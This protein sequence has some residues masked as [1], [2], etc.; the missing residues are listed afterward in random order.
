MKEYFSERPFARSLA[1]FI[2]E[3]NQW[4]LIKCGI[5]NYFR[6]INVGV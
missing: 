2:P 4:L 3:T 6:E 5:R 1:K